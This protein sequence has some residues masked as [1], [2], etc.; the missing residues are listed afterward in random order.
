MSDCVKATQK[1]S[2][3][4]WPHFDSQNSDCGMYLPCDAD[5]FILPLT[6][7]PGLQLGDKRPDSLCC[8]EDRMVQATC[9]YS[10]L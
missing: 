3:Q 1:A 4:N 5:Q 2:D 8:Y 6:L 9:A 10:A 7:F